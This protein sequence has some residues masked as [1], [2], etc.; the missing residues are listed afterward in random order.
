M[1]W[2][3]RDPIRLRALPILLAGVAGVTAQA[4]AMPPSPMVSG[5]GY[6]GGRRIVPCIAGLLMPVS[7]AVDGPVSVP[8]RPA[9][10]PPVAVPGAEFRAEPGKIKIIQ[11]ERAM[12]RAPGLALCSR[13]ETRLPVIT[14][15][16]WHPQDQALPAR[17]PGSDRPKS[18]GRPG[19][20]KDGRK[21]DD[22]PGE[23][24]EAGGPCLVLK[25][26]EHP[27]TWGTFGDVPHALARTH[28]SSDGADL[29]SR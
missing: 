10:R 15:P 26:P 18:R 12:A 20:G 22:H 11:P 9:T 29:V 3:G 1:R 17:H 19:T 13:R 23:P 8:R 25:W 14:A 4:Q 28:A 6:L 27:H 2:G 5:V 7:A 21:R 24:P 16:R